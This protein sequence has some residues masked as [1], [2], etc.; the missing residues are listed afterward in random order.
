MSFWNFSLETDWM[1]LQILIKEHLYT[2]LTFNKYSC[3]QVSH[4]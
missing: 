3:F 2:E 4:H 1:L